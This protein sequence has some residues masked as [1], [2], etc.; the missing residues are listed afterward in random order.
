MA[1][2]AVVVVADH[3]PRSP[4]TRPPNVHTIDGDRH[5]DSR[6]ERGDAVTARHLASPGEI[7]PTL[8]IPVRLSSLG[9]AGSTPAD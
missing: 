8:T 7:L 5:P 2:V 4:A 9:P 6:G 1:V 3:S